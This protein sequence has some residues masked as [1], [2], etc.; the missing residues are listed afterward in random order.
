MLGGRLSCARTISALLRSIRFTYSRLNV[1]A[2]LSPVPF[3]CGLQ[4]GV[5]TNS[6]FAG[7]RVRF[8]SAVSATVIAQD[9]ELR[10]SNVGS[11]KACF[12]SFNK[13]VAYR[14]AWQASL[15]PGATG[16]ELAI[17]AVFHKHASDDLAVV[18]GNL[19]AIGTPALI[20]LACRHDAV[21]Y[22]AADGTLW[23][24]RQQQTA[25][26]HHAVKTLVVDRL[27]THQRARAVD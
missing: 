17:A 13:H 16:N 1:L 19:E 20:R 14:F 8:V 4:T 24:F 12:D 18:A 15:G 10:R 21:M 7:Q 3:D 6:Q 23:R 22:T 2:K 9:L 27:Q 26:F 25:G 11:D 5:C